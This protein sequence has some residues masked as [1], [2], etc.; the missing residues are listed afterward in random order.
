MPSPILAEVDHTAVA[1]VSF[2]DAPAQTVL[3][4][5]RSYEVDMVRHKAVSPDFH[6]A[7]LAPFGHQG[8]VSLIVFIVKESRQPSIAPLSNMV[9]NTG[10]YNTSD[11]S[12]ERKLTLSTLGVNVELSKVSP[13]LA[14]NS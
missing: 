13:E 5:R 14:Q 12:H 7:L 11:S 8:N 4:F 2:T 10:S 6:A 1:P 3:G 9:G